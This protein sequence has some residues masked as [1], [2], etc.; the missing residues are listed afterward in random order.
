MGLPGPMGMKGES[1]S[2]TTDLMVNLDHEEKRV[3]QAFLALMAYPAYRVQ[4]VQL[5]MRAKPAV[6][7][8]RALSERRVKEEIRGKCQYAIDTIQSAVHRTDHSIPTIE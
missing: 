5:E 3:N 1:A 6:E 2:V 8:R 4:S 7:A